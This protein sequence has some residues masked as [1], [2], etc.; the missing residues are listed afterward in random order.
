[1]GEKGR[2][3]RRRRRRRIKVDETFGTLGKKEE[4]RG[5]ERASCSSVAK[6]EEK[7]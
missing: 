1:M 7:N 3:R 2:R 6:E 5:E 4:K